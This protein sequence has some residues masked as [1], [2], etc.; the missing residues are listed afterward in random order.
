MKKKILMIGP[1]PE[2]ITGMSL[3]NKMLYDGLKKNYNVQFI[4]TDTE[5]KINSAKSQGKFD[6]KKVINSFNPILLGINKILF[7]NFDVIYITPAQSYLGF[8]K[9][10][11]FIKIAKWMKIPCYIHFHG[12]FV[13]KMYDSLNLK[14]K[15]RIKK[16]F[17]ET[18]GII[19]LGKSLVYMLDEIVPKEKV[20]VCENGIESEFLINEEEL[21]EKL[22]KKNEDINILYLSNLMKTKGIIELLDAALIMKQENIKFILN[23]AGGIEIDIEN[24]VKNKIN[25]L[26]ENIKYHGIV[27]GKEKKELLKKANIFCLPTYYPNEGQPISILEA[28]GN[29]VAIVTTYQGG[30]IDIFK[31]R[32]NGIRCNERDEV[33]IKNAIVEAYDKYNE[34][35]IENYKKCKKNYISEKFVERIEK[36]IFSKEK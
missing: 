21:E 4:D 12:G 15:N 10:S 24:E 29:G 34:F 26:G 35:S 9:Y 31:D 30:I 16:L 28:M 13:K 8:M 18:S 1:F 27:K 14:R 20:H 11:L 32:L 33:S 36:I 3:A 23:I 2:P 5:K 25:L 22:R 6:L 7:S 17:N 19:V